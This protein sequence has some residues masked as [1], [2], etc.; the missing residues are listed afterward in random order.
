MRIVVDCFGGDD[1][2]KSAVLGALD[3]LK[4]DKSLQVI[5]AGRQ[6]TIEAVL[7]AEKYDKD[8]VT[9]LDCIEQIEN[10]E[11]PS[12]AIRQKTESSMVKGLKLLKEDST[13]D[14]FV[15]QGSTGALLT[16][17]LLLLGRIKGVS[18]PAVCP[19]LPNS[20]G[21]RVFILDAGANN[22]NTPQ[23]L[24]H[25]ALMGAMYAQAMGI[26]SPRVALLSNGTERHKGTAIYQEAYDLIEANKAIHFVGNIEGREILSGN[27]DVVVA[28]GYAGNVALKTVEGT[29]LA[30]MQMLRET[31]QSSFWAKVGALFMRPSLK[32]LRKILN[33]TEYG[34]AVFLGV[35]KVV[36]KVHGAGNVQSISNAIL[37][38]Q[39][40]AKSNLIEN[41]KAL[42]MTQN[43]EQNIEKMN[44][45]DNEKQ[46][47]IEVKM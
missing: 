12:V 14:G 45:Q 27:V 22:E 30:V 9:I 36:V 10:D 5:L 3:A 20:K 37:Q 1:A 8:R 18:R 29:A 38:A 24:Y 21:G 33:Y 16:G 42:L 28:D 32:K 35:N 44:E 11:I 40:M 7:H 25:F 19:I 4:Q 6:S 23:H 46:N 17:A 15:G 47:D 26:K 39:E 2:P 43:S 31:I 41:I 13:V 34:G